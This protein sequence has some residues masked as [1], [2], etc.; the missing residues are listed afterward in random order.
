MLFRSHET[1]D[2]GKEFLLNFNDYRVVVKLGEEV[3][4]LEA[5]GY[6]VVKKAN[7]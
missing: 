4:T 1:F 2:N 3:Y 7:A 6:V 5:Y